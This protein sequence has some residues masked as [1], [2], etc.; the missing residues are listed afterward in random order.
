MNSTPSRFSVILI[1]DDP[2]VQEVNRQF[3][4]RI[5]GFRVEAAA[6]NGNEG[7]QLIRTMRPDLVFLDIFMPGLGGIETLAQLRSEQ[8][9]VEVIVVSA[10]NDQRTVEQMLR[11]GA[12]DYIM[13]PFKFERVR[14]ALER[15]RSMKH[16]LGSEQPL[17]QADLD[18]LR[19]ASAA[20]ADD[21]APAGPSELPKGLQAVTMKQIVGFLSGQARPLSAEEVAE[22]V[23]I[24]R[25]TARRYLDYLE[26]NGRVRLDLQY[27]VGRPVNT[28]VM[29]T[30]A[31][32]WL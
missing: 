26:K 25:V 2:M 15:F 12:F 8:F 18:R 7:L 32:G 19:F 30:K 5:E 1:E 4:E 23:G 21:A 6:S 31:D 13:K 22:G 28:Y 20:H 17:T 10:A 27:G 11:N 16:T 14:Q 24:A 29:T 3:I 9:P